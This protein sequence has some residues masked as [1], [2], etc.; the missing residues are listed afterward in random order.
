M[1]GTS[2]PVF[3][4]CCREGRVDL[5]LLKQAP[6]FLNALLDYGG[7]RRASKFHENIRAYNSMFAF[8]S[9][10][11]RI[12]NEINHRSRPYVFWINEQNH[13]RMGLL[14]P[15]MGGRPKFAQLYIYDIKNEVSNRHSALNSDDI[16]SDV[17]REIVARLILRLLVGVS[18]ELLYS[19]A[20]LRFRPLYKIK[21][22]RNTCG[23]DE[24]WSA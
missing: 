13:H 14:L 21:R 18:N 2:R 16:S 1:H 5:P 11:A 8:T 10:R 19:G 20:L 12:D 15:I 6:D 3:M 7:G 17:D 9:I 24:R 4:L 22:H 23:S